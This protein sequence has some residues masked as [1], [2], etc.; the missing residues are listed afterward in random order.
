MRALDC[1]QLWMDPAPAYLGTLQSPSLSTS[2]PYF[3]GSTISHLC[4]HVSAYRST[5]LILFDLT[6]APATATNNFNHK[7]TGITQ[8]LLARETKDPKDRST[9]PKIFNYLYYMGSKFLYLEL[10]QHNHLLQGA[11]PTG[12]TIRLGYNSMG[13]LLLDN[14]G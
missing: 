10:S 7:L 13:F 11:R 5:A 12:A 2:A 4:L 3:S 8:K 6:K 9:P 1:Q 14:I